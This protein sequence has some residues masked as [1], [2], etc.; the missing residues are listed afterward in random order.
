MSMAH[1]LE[2]RVPFLDVAV[3]D[4]AFRIPVELKQFGPERSEK[5]ILRKSA[6][7]LL[8]D[9]VAWRS[10]TKFAA[11][12]GLGD[13]LA[14]LAEKEIGDADFA[15]RREI[16]DGVFLRS[17][18]ELFYFRI[19]KQMYPRDDLLPLVGRSRSV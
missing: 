9:G 3:V 4:Y 13:R 7:S 10:K 18:E 2:V 12:S 1:G 15:R 19:F 16:A 14:R 17:K 6:E 5:W 11:G 8:P